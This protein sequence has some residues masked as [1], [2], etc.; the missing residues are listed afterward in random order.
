MEHATNPPRRFLSL[1]LL[2]GLITLLL[3]GPLAAQPSPQ[4]KLGFQV[5]ADRKLADWGQI[6]AYFRDLDRAS[7]RVEVVELGKT[8]LGRPFIMAVISSAQNLRDQEGIRR[9]VERL[10]HPYNLSDEEMH[11]L[12]ERGK[13]VVMISCSIH[14]TEIGASQM[15]M[16]LAYRL[17]SQNDPQTRDILDNVV[18]LLLPSVNPD[19]IDIVTDWYRKTLGTKAEGTGPP[20]IYHHYAGHD[21]NRDWFMLNLK[22]SRLVTRVLYQEWFPQ[23]LY[24]VHQMGSRGA[25][26][27]VPPFYEVSNPNIDPLILRQ[28]MQI[29]G[30]MTTDLAA[31]GMKGVATEAIFDTWWHG[32]M[33]TAPYYHNVV[34]LLSEAASAR[35]ATPVEIRFKELRGSRR[36][37]PSVKKFRA[38]FPEPWPGGW[39]HLR[40]II[41][42][43]LTA[44]WSLL[45]LAARYRADWLTNF[46]IMGRR[47]IERGRKEKPFAYVIPADQ[48]DRGNL[49]HLI[50]VLMWQGVE[51]Q[52]A[53]QPFVADGR[54]YPKGTYVILAAQPY[55]ADVKALL[56]RQ[57]YPERRAYPGGPLERPYDVTGWTLSLQMGVDAIEVA[58]SFDAKLEKLANPPL[59]QLRLP[60]RQP[61]W[62]YLLPAEDTRA[63]QAVNR[64]LKKG[65]Q[66]YRA[67]EAVRVAGRQFAAGAV[68]VPAR[69]LPPARLRDW[70]QGVG[71]EV[72]AVDE[73][74]VGQ[75]Y[76]L[77]SARVAVYQSWV[78]SMDEGWT[79]FVLDQFEFPYSTVH[80][81][82]IRQGDLEHDFDVVVLPSQRDSTIIR[83]HNGESKELRYPKEYRGGIGAVGVANLH[84]FVENGGTL[85]ALGAATRLPIKSFWLPVTNVLEGV[86]AKQFSAPGSILQTLVDTTHPIGYGMR[87]ET[88]IFFANS[89]TFSVSGGTVIARY[90]VSNPLLSGWLD[91]ADK[92]FNKAGLVEV[93]LGR[94]RVIL[95]G[96]RPQHRGQTWGTFKLLFN[97]LYYAVAER[98]ELPGALPSD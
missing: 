3:A 70:L 8:T 51:V 28:I 6:T 87:R 14:S 20:R 78:P 21:N 75:G 88:A 33:R 35:I 19:G 45:R 93:P 62:A 84:A 34:G 55:R 58:T 95:F 38:N 79:R 69:N 50:E 71:I 40:D 5:G 89:P 22:E 91:G 1:L 56:E 17:A 74:L 25:R 4:S 31:A 39:W 30:H 90:P 60:A 97:T 43:E 47:A 92:L 46:A 11:R 72:E 44:S 54:P 86:P 77:R 83:G 10:A 9:I 57:H 7:D 96:F 23:I 65:V 49:L 61:K 24:D 98:T 73:P 80:D 66:I 63:A 18:L 64:L 27:F 12:A 59:P 53:R 85:V 32:G 13:T 76:R 16:E 68:L 52:R 67:A 29:G 41:D 36:G 42:Y 2:Q 15:S 26:F 81:D 94:G 48:R 37:L 82:R